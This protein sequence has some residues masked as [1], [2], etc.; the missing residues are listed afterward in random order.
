MNTW[1]DDA[2]LDDTIC[3]CCHLQ[4]SLTIS[5]ND[6]Q[7]KKG[8]YYSIFEKTFFLHL[9]GPSLAHLTQRYLKN[10]YQFVFSC[11]TQLHTALIM[12]RVELVKAKLINLQWPEW[13]L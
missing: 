3:K 13:D 4:F 1:V 8:E 10:Y 12:V 6:K 5:I 9:E 7:N 2:D 11:Q